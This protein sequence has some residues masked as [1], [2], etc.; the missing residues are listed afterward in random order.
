MTPKKLDKS[1][2]I[3]QKGAP[4]L[5]ER[6]KDIRLKDLQTPYLEDILSKMSTALQK[7]KN[8]VGLAAPQMGFSLR[9]FIV[10]EEVFEENRKKSLSA[11]ETAEQR[12]KAW[13]PTVFINPKIIKMSSKKKILPEGCL[14]VNNI[15]GK[16]KR[17]E[18]VIFEALNEKGEK[19]KRGASGLL[20]QVVQHE[21]DHLNGVLFVE[22]ATEIKNDVPNKK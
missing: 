6:A 3:F 4:I 14:S 10:S 8:G 21:I 18:K 12:R 13:K 2:P 1:L 5:N 22:K 20:A 17:S 19:I 7:A 15:Y 16:V 9:I 11:E